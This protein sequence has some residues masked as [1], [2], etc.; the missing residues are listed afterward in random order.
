MKMRRWDSRS[1]V[2]EISGAVLEDEYYQQQDDNTDAAI[3]EIEEEV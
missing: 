1:D 3:A 2:S